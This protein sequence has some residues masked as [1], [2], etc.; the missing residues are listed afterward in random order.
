MGWMWQRF[1]DEFEKIKGKITRGPECKMLGDVAGML[2]VLHEEVEELKVEVEKVKKLAQE[3]K[4]GP[5]WGR[6]VG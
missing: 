4:R 3:A 1:W 6:L 5:A 2:W